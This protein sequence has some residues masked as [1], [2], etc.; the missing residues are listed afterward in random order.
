[1]QTQECV[2]TQ[3]YMQTFEFL[4]EITSLLGGASSWMIPIKMSLHGSAR[5]LTISGLGAVVYS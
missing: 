4:L 3:E 2:K 1:M 5:T